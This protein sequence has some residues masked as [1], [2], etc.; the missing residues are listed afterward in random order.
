MDLVAVA[1]RLEARDAWT[2]R[3]DPRSKAPDSKICSAIWG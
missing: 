2:Y 1:G 3:L